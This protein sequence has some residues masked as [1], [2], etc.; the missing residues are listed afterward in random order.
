MLATFASWMLGGEAIAETYYVSPSGS[1]NRVRVQAQDRSTPWQTLQHAVNNAGSGDTVIALEGTYDEN[2]FLPRGGFP[3]QPFT[4]KA[5]YREAGRLL[6][7]IGCNDRSHLLVD[8]FDVTNNSPT[9]ITK[10]IQMTRCSHV[11]VRDCRVRNCFGGGIGFDQS[12]WIQCEWNI[13]HDNAFFDVNQHSGISVYQPQYRG[14]SDER[15]GVIIRNNTS[16]GNKNLVNNPDFGRPTDGNGIVVDDFFN[17][18]S[19]GNEVAYDRMS[20]IENNI[21]FDNG[22]QGV[23]CYRS[24]NVRIRNNTCVNNME[25]FDFGGE[26]SVS[27]SERVNVYNNILVAREGKR[28]ALKFDSRDV[29]FGFN[30]INGPVRDVP[31]DRNSVYRPPFFEPGSFRLRGYSPAINKGRRYDYFFLDAYGQPRMGRGQRVDLGAVERQ[32]EW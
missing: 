5:E 21:C 6:G 23:H 8:G 28:A 16:F 32:R 18:Q 31:Y 25:S 24:Q 12:D 1:D 22:G 13:V 15:Y 17:S 30:L 11:T 9:G 7:W 4:L 27:E 29:Y 14:D 20:V 10:G 2:V 26:V 3:G 19:G